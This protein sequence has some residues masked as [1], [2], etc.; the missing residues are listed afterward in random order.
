MNKY[1]AKIGYS[2]L[3]VLILAVIAL[4]FKSNKQWCIP[5]DDTSLLLSLHNLFFIPILVSAF[6]FDRIGTTII[7]LL[8]AIASILTF[9][10][11]TESVSNL[12]IASVSVRVAFFIVI[13]YMAGRFAEI[14]RANTAEWQSLLQVSRSINSKLELDETL[15]EIIDRSVALSSADACSIQLLDTN[16]DLYYAKTK[17][18]SDQFIEAGSK[19]I[20][21]NP[22]MK[23]SLS[24]DDVI[25]TSVR[26]ANNLKHRDIILEEGIQAIMSIP[27]RHADDIV[28]ILNLY[29]KKRFG[30]KKRDKQLADAFAEHAVIAIQ[31]AN[32][33]AN[34]RN[35]YLETVKALTRAIEARDSVTHG[36]SER[37]M[38]ISVA[39]AKV[40][41]LSPQDIQTI[42]FGSMLHDIGKIGLDA[43]ILDNSE[44][45]T[46]DEKM[47]LEMHPMI[48]KSIIEPVEFL[49][50]CLPIVLY[51]HEYWD[52]SGY[53]EGLKNGQIP[54]LA[55]IVS[56]AESFDHEVNDG[57]KRKKPLEALMIMKGDNGVKYDPEMLRWLEKALRML[58]DIPAPAKDKIEETATIAS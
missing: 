46:I 48:G 49:R 37:V 53:P 28:G 8:A 23:K 42:E 3:F 7:A 54:H 57:V 36:H 13:G 52:G 15:E 34:I 51:H 11:P 30:F 45:M 16:L 14:A 22:D 17:G 44:N 19:I 9:A 6:V 1:K 50:P 20:R 12:F 33:Y 4:F 18:L 26:K 35:N 25:I 31:N 27:L 40:M 41:K 10:P 29:R 47:M 39:M 58:G 55:H 5:N 43:E 56:V 21:D 24:G 32:L 2:A 38:R